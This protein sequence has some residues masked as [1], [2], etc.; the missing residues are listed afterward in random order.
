MPKII[1]NIRENLLEEA[2]RQVMEEGYSAMTIRSVAGA[3]G[4]GVGTVYNY[5][6]S[7]DMLIAS[8]M[9]SDWQECMEAIWNCSRRQT[10]TQVGSLPGDKAW[11]NRPEVLLRCIY[12]QLKAFS[13]KYA[14]LFADEN[15]GVSFA[16]AFPNRHRQLRSQIAEP[17]YA[18]CEQQSK[19]DPGFLA[20]FLAESMLTWVLADRSFEEISSVLLQLF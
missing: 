5:F 19:A 1:E 20:E 16:S 3:C 18:V 8:F 2:R 14:P 17:L 10:D 6:P 9:L 15:A 11:Y 4:V 12:D 7:K 13:K